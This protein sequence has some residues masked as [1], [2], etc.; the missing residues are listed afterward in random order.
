MGK[1]I[2]MN[3]PL[4]AL[5]CAINSKYVHSSLAPWYLLEGVKK[6]CSHGVKAE[7]RE[8]TINMDLTTVALDIANLKPDVIGFSCYI[9]NISFIKKLIEIIKSKLPDVII[10]LGGPEVSYNAVAVLTEDTEVEFVLSGEGEVPFA[11]LLDALYDSKDVG[12]VPGV[13][14][15][16]GGDM[17]I[18]EP[19]IPSEDPP[20]PYSDDYFENLHGRIA[21]LETSRGCSFSCAFCLSGRCGN[22]R[23]FD[24][25]RA[26]KEIILLANSGT[27]TVKFIDRT[28]NLNRERACEIFRFII[29]NQK[30]MIPEDVCFHFEIAGDLL[31]DETINILSKAPPGLIQFEIG[32]QSFHSKTL[33][34]VNR[35]TD[36]QCLVK[37]IERLIAMANIHIHI[38]LIAG[39]PYEDID[40]FG[41]SFNRA[42]N[43]K[44]HM[45]QLGFL[46]LLHG[47]PMRDEPN[48]FPCS[49][50]MLP[51]YEV[52]ETPWLR[53]DKL[54]LLHQTE[55]ALERLYNCGRF[56]RTLAY[57]IE[58]TGLTPFAFFSKFGAYAAKTGER[59]ISLDEYTAL[60]FEYFGTFPSIDKLVLRDKVVCDRMATNSSGKL[61]AILK[62]KDPAYKKIINTCKLM[63]GVPVGKKTRRGYAI[64]YSEHKII[65]VDYQTQNPVT[66]EYRLT[67]YNHDDFD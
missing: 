19:Y 13:C 26:K 66:G 12:N 33:L 11:M 36:I 14:Q 60:V 22:V 54:A 37:N 49:F 30:D 32:L 63:D 5:I 44:P 2:V 21:Y 47:S 65:W 53:G 1:G 35:K 46:K 31:D 58:R 15:K 24:L 34:A 9:W 8:F 56:R 39:L 48:R 57:L 67:E 18:S 38:D 61:P 62:V 6:Y 41:Q 7:V 10:I 45:L 64:L 27:Q 50:S 17:I 42:Y 23:F 20:S 59:G 52:T 29:E 4:H 16:S 3:K 28:F 40:T 43:L 55:N 51:P 25:D